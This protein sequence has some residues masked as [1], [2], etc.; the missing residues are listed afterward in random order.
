MSYV[1]EVIQPGETVVLRA[2]LHW[3]IYARGIILLIVA[4]VIAGAGSALVPS[5]AAHET[6]IMSLL[7]LATALLVAG[8]AVLYL[9][10]AF[11]R[12]ATTEVAVTTKRVIYNEGSKTRNRA[13]TPNPV[14]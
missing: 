7:P 3:V 1:D 8:T 11:V 2:P 14:K 10:A 4:G 6:D 12:R 5:P 9:L 13:G